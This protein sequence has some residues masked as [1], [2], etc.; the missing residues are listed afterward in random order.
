MFSPALR[1][2][3]W[4]SGV[5][6]VS[7]QVSVRNGPHQKLHMHQETLTKSHPLC[8]TI[9][10]LQVQTTDKFLLKCIRGQVCV[11]ARARASA[12]V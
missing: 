1:I 2:L 8:E 12:C 9:T 10:L 11:C 7:A 4:C 3:T 5:Y 6:L